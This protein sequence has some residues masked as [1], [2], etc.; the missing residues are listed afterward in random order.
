MTAWKGTVLAVLA[1]GT[2]WAGGAPQKPTE[3]ELEW[4]APT[5]ERSRVNPLPSSPEAL[6]RGRAL[7]RVHCAVCHGDSGRGDGPAA[8]PHARFAA[9]P[10]NLTRAE[11]QRRLTDGEIFW[12]LSTGL[13]VRERIVMPKFQ[14]E[15]RSE[16][17][18]WMVVSYVRSLRTGNPSE[19]FDQADPNGCL[20][21][22]DAA[23][24]D[25]GD[26]ER[27]ASRVALADGT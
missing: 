12:K 18:R 3:A 5:A 24:G 19:D 16:E 7:F 4:P 14:D 26:Q 22:G 1:A 21:C 6:K 27:R 2:A 17:D 13:R 8:R 15:I 11:V 9:P 10:R 23:H 20:A 25:L